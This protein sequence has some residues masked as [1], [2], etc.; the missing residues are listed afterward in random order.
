[1]RLALTCFVVL[2]CS[3]LAGCSSI[4]GSKLSAWAVPEAFKSDEKTAQIEVEEDDKTQLVG[5]RVTISGM[6][7]PLIE[8]VGLVTGLDG[9][10]GDVPPSTYRRMILEDMKKRRVE[11]PQKVLQS[12]AT[13]VVVVRAFLPPLAKDGDKLDIE[14][15][16]PPGS[17]ATSLRGGWLLPT[18]MYE[19]G[20]VAGRGQIRDDEAAVAK[21]PILISAGDATDLKN[22]GVVR[23]GTIPGGAEYIGEDR[24]LSLVLRS[25]YRSARNA[26]RIADR[27]GMRFHGFDDYGVRKPMAEAKTDSRIELMIPDVYRDNFPRYLKVVRRV[28][29]GES[30]I[31]TRIRIERLR[32]DLLNPV[33]SE[34]SALQL[35]AIG[36]DASIVLREA[37]SSRSL[38]CRFQAAA[39]LAYLGDEAG[40]EVLGEA[41]DQDRALRVWSMLAMSSLQGGEAIPELVKL[42]DSES[43]ETRYGAVRALTTVDEYHP[44]VRGYELTD[45]A[46]LR[47]L[48]STAAP[49][50]HLTKSQKSE[51][52]LF[53]GEQEFN[54]PLVARAGSKILVVGNAGDRSVRLSR[55]A[56]G[57][58]DQTRTVSPL[59]SDVIR[60]AAE[61]GATYPDLVSL[62]LET[63]KQHN[64]P[65]SIAIDALPQ[66][67]RMYVGGA[68]ATARS[69]DE[70]DSQGDREPFDEELRR[71]SEAVDTQNVETQ[72]EDDSSQPATIES[73][74]E[75]PAMQPTSESGA[76]MPG[77][78]TTR[79][80]SDDRSMAPSSS[81]D[82]A[83]ANGELPPA[84][85]E[86]AFVR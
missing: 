7:T 10:G 61:L 51:I 63:D 19:Q 45:R 84:Q 83:D 29:V 43:I 11:N 65:G 1:M 85:G 33:K 56:P 70:G 76:V 22:A 20:F 16:L 79:E 23:K 13:A 74:G 28:S 64:L 40:V 71:D 6:T 55:F 18:L 58:E 47:V 41:A 73:D 66:G 30:P 59:I 34:E 49:V 35:E 31:E 78:G 48:N 2:F 32:E 24:T 12:P 3:V 14:V 15:I 81:A 62:L 46:V 38:F 44:A 86:P 26:K 4:L 57:E 53:G 25:D 27:V 36:K 60:A 77:H 21:G 17:E 50:V 37:L 75:T 68:F 67:G 69:T 82:S 54:L 9:T 80:R 8:G 52:T 39:A 72:A 5:S 42:L